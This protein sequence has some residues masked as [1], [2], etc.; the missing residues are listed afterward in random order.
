MGQTDGR[1]GCVTGVGLLMRTR[2]I[3]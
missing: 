2:K 1:T 3:T